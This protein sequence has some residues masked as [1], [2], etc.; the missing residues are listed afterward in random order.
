MKKISLLLLTTLMALSL[1]TACDNDNNEDND[2][3]AA[4][5][6]KWKFV[7]DDVVVRTSDKEADRMIMIDFEAYLEWEKDPTSIEFTTLGTFF[8]NNELSGTYTVEGNKMYLKYK[9][10]TI[11]GEFKVK[12]GNLSVSRSFLSYYEDEQRHNMPIDDGVKIHEVSHV[13]Y[14]SK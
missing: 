10:E 3:P 2:N 12:D 4:L 11:E 9:T 14:Y 8:V 5:I 6:G 13:Q 1:F 7:G